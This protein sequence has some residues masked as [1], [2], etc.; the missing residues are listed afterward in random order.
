MGSER[1]WVPKTA[2][3]LSIYT[4]PGAEFETEF[5]EA[6]GLVAIWTQLENPHFV[7]SSLPLP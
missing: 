6:G 4:L 7:M 3:S 1:H 2:R 5:E